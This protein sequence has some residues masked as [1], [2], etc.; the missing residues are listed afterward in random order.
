MTCNR[1]HRTN[2]IK[3]RTVNNRQTVVDTVD[4]ERDGRNNEAVRRH[5]VKMKT[6]HKRN[7]FKKS[8]I[9]DQQGH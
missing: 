4:L 9:K 6:R 3:D 5:T 7:N 1:V 8:K 2:R